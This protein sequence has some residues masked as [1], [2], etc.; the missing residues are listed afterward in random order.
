MNKIIFDIN[1]HKN[2]L[3]VLNKEFEETKS[4]YIE[5]E[6]LKSKIIDLE[7]L[8]NTVEEKQKHEFKIKDLEKELLDLDDNKES[9]KKELEIFDRRYNQILSFSIEHK[10]IKEKIL[11]IESDLL[12]LE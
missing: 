9:I 4:Y 7:S 6:N 5:I 3:D 2:N 11:Y 8:K 10:D 1:F 12:N